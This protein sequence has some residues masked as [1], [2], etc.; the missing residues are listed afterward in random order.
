MT[1]AEDEDIAEIPDYPPGWS[2]EQRVAA[3]W[4]ALH[5]TNMPGTT[6]GWYAVWKSL[7]RER[8]RRGKSYNAMKGTE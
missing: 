4:H 2:S 6:E 3:Y 1:Y 7:E 5:F 8:E